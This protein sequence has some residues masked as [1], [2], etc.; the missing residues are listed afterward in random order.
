MMT[1][2]FLMAAVLFL[3]FDVDALSAD[4]HV[5]TGMAYIEQGLPDKAMGEFI[6][7]LEISDQAY[8][9][10]LGLARIAVINCSWTTAEEEYLIYMELR[11]ENYRAPLEMAEMLLTVYG[12]YP[13]ALVFAETALS[14]APLNGECW[15]VL[16]D[17][18]GRLGN[19][20]VATTWYRRI[21]TENVELADEARV[22]MGSL[23]FQHGDLPEAREVLLPAASSGKAEAHHI[24]AVM[25]LEQN[26]E[27]RATDSINRYL[28]LEPNGHWAD[29]ARMCLDELL[30][31]TVELR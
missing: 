30:S 24:L 13:D 29:S 11:P 17:T 5:E 19:I 1:S 21:F 8:E 10:H 15:L 18:E 31:G 2:C 20:E 22:R 4:L 6:T 26:D 9:A 27:L 12:R 23:L 25:Y 3:D 7:A 14:L 28:Y 16:A